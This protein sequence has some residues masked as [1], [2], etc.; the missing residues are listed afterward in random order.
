MNDMK[1]STELHTC[2]CP[3][4]NASPVTLVA[5]SQRV[6]LTNMAPSAEWSC[7]R[8]RNRSDSTVRDFFFLFN[9]THPTLLMQVSV[10]PAHLMPEGLET[11]R[12]HCIPIS[13]HVAS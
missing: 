7:V 8:L 9:A 1:N 3:S 12:S 11:K 13:S 6:E 4:W 5:R 2:L 10:T